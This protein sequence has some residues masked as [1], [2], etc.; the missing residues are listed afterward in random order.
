[1]NTDTMQ[2]LSGLIEQS[3]NRIKEAT[4]GVLDITDNQL[5]SHLRQLISN[6]LGNENCFLADPV[7]EH[8]FGWKSADCTFADL[9]RQN[10]FSTKLTDVLA[11]ADRYGFP[12]TAR[13]YT[14]QLQAWKHLLG[15]AP[16]S[17]IIT[18]GTGSGKTECFMIPILEDL[19]RR[20]TFE[21]NSAY[22]CSGSVSLPT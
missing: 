2:T 10:L 11:D 21:K 6:E 22:R 19:I 20:Q 3:L 18:S 4:I 8:T 12:K 7:V 14:H 5:R 1:M 17:A 9:V 13:P 15:D 16:K